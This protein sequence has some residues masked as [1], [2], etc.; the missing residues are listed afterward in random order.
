MKILRSIRSVNPAI[1]GPIESVRQSSAQLTERGHEV[2]IVSLDLPG[3]PWTREM[4]V[5]VHALGESRST[6]GYS[7]GFEPWLRARRSA[8]DIV[9]VQGV[10]QYSSFGVWRALRG[11]ETPY[12]VFPHGMLDPW[13]KR[14]YPLKHL[15][16]LLYWPWAEARVLRDAAVVLF[17]SEEER[18]LAREPFPFYRCREAVVSYGT[19]APE[20]DLDAA[21]EDFLQRWPELRGKRILLFLSRLHVKK[22]PDLLIQAFAKVQRD[23]LH[24]VLA[25]PPAND[26][27]Q[28]EL[29]ALVAQSFPGGAAPVTFTGMLSGTTKWGA[30]GAAEAFVLPSHQENFGISVAEALATGLPVLISNCVNIWREIVADGAGFAED[31]DLAG[32]TRLLARWEEA[33]PATR[34]AMREKARACFAQRFE[35]QAAVDSLLDQLQQALPA[36]AAR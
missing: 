24:L 10:W 7:K 12:V 11:G 4:P 22:G 36:R 15:K 21:R 6:Y 23:D 17:T 5:P 32:T 18:R 27:Y 1:G 3:D 30:F 20:V 25:G 13:F 34:A 33:G 31:D 2:E 8:Y 29:E 14:T 35:I 26:E 19:A 9:I 28:R 16:K